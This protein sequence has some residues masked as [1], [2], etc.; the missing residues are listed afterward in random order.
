MKNPIQWLLVGAI[1]FGLVF[2][3]TRWGS[4]VI[5]QP[6]TIT[7][8]GYAEREEK[9]QVAQFY[10][11]V[12]A[13]N[14]DKQLAINEVNEQ[15]RRVTEKLKT[16]GIADADI[17]TQSMSV[18]QDQE[19]VTEGG[20]QRYTAG[21]WRANNSVQ[22]K[23]RDGAR[24]SEL[25]SLLG[26]SGLT[27][28]SG[29]NFSLDSSDEQRADLLQKAVE[30]AREK[31]DFLAKANKKKIYGI[32]SITEGYSSNPGLYEAT[33]MGGGGG[34]PVEPGTSTVTAAATVVFELK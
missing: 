18:Y 26:E 4:M 12:T 19:Q 20:R 28:I 27:D 14:A 3:M 17:Q 34:G 33:K 7:V 25:M 2:P 1:F 22:I 6:Q 31:A 21:G 13:T 5:R 23:L 15:M 32:V 30:K 16:F 29:P 9:N 11:G 24:T 8:T 10:A